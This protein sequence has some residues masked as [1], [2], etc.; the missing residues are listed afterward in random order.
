M[1]STTDDSRNDQTLNP[2][3]GNTIQ[4]NQNGGQDAA[5]NQANPATAN[6]DANQ[7]Q[8]QTIHQPP[9]N[10]QTQQFQN[11]N[12]PQN[13][14]NNYNS[15]G[16]NGGYNNG[17]YNMGHMHHQNQFQPTP[18]QPLSYPNYMN[19][20]F[21]GQQPQ[22]QPQPQP[23]FQHQPPHYMPPHNMPLPPP[24]Q[25][26]AFTVPAPPPPPPPQATHSR[27]VSVNSFGDDSGS[28]VGSDHGEEEQFSGQVSDK[29]DAFMEQSQVKP[30]E[31]PQICKK[32]A[33][34]M[35]VHL[36]QGFI[37]SDLDQSIKEYP[38][39]MNV[40]LAWAPELES[41]IFAHTRFQNNKPVV[42]TEV[43]LK[44][45]QRGIASSINA[46]G[47]LTEIIMRQSVNNPE[48]D[49]ASTVLLDIIKLLTNS[50]GGLTKKRRDLLKPAVDG[51]YSQRLA[52]KDED[53][54]PVYLFGGNVGDRVRKYKA[55]DSLMKDV[56]KPEQKSSNNGG[57]RGPPNT[58]R[59]M[60]V[61]DPTGNDQTIVLNLT[62]DH[63]RP[64]LPLQHARTNQ[65][66]IFAIRGLTNR[67]T[68]VA[69]TTTT[70][71]TKPTMATATTGH[72]LSGE[73]HNIHPYT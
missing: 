6:T 52:K 17:S 19:G 4:G 60:L 46:L 61:D 55:T 1:A 8:T 32:L 27:P 23:Y 26:Q 65:G 38:P 51:K 71:T 45:V 53:F 29:L 34:F 56:M 21:H 12:Q 59:P 64:P 7:S 33:H 43:A 37:T 35:M 54:N 41:D 68:T 11:F 63:P 5:I 73:P 58:H 44:S 28:E 72:R 39:L 36:E 49:N 62:T 18:A 30:T 42:A 13:L 9:S 40:P 22:Y 2:G 25:N 66:R 48:L 10:A 24:P 47:P 67:G 15:T 31:G 70:P 57:Q 16:F 50:M 69:T 20:G 3:D 14:N